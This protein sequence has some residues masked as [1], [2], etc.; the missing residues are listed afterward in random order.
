M[1]LQWRTC[2][3]ATPGNVKVYNRSSVPVTLRTTGT[4]KITTQRDTHVKVDVHGV[5]PEVGDA[6]TY[7]AGEVIK[8]HVHSRRNRS[9]MLYAACM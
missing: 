5:G 3:G 7:Q 9:N 8:G 6:R 4:G 1:V 2:F